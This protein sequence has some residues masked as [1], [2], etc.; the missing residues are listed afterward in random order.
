MVDY[1]SCF[2]VIRKLDSMTTK[3]VTS[4]TKSILEEHGVPDTIVTDSSPCFERKE[5]QEM[6]SVL[7]IEVIMNIPH[8]P[9]T[10]DLA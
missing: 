2:Q 7:G 6:Y 8:Y 9:Q 4:N 10:K 1:T 3:Q 5:Y